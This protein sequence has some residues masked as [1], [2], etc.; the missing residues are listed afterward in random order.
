MELFSAVLKAR[1]FLA[2]ECFAGLLKKLSKIL[3]YSA[4]AI[5]FTAWPALSKGQGINLSQEEIDYIRRAGVIKAV[6]IAGV[7][8]LQY[9]NSK[10][11]VQGISWRIL[12]EISGMTGLVFEYKLYNTV[13]EGLRSDGDI[14]FTATRNYAPP[15]MALSKPFFKTE[16]IIFMNSRLEAKN[17]DEEIYAG[18]K[19]GSLPK[20]VREEKR[21][22]YDNREDCLNAV[23]AGEAGYGYGNAYSVA[24]YTLQNN[25]KN[26]IT[27]PWGKDTREYHI[28]MMKDDETL[29]GILNKA[30]DNI[31]EQTLSNL[32][33]EVTSRIERK[34]TLGVVLETYGI[35]LVSAASLLIGALLISVII[36]I[37]AKNRLLISNQRHE[38]LSRISNEYFFEYHIDCD[39]FNLSE[40]LGQRVDVANHEK[41]IKSALKT[42]RRDEQGSCTSIIKLPFIDGGT[43]VFKSISFIIYKRGGK[44]H[45]IVGKLVD[46]SQEYMEKEMLITKSQID[47]LSGLYN[48]A[49]AKELMENRIKDKGKA[50]KDALMIIDL[51]NFKGIND[52]LGHIVGDMVLQSIASIMKD[53][54]RKTD[55]LG[56]IGGDEFCVYMKDIASLDL[57]M[58]K[59]RQLNMLTREFLADVSYTVSIGIALTD[60][61]TG[62]VRELLERADKA[63]YQ[64]KG[65][66]PGQVALAESRDS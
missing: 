9:L 44:P 22:E 26:I 32:I 39:K 52:T 27:I 37:R 2:R 28:G 19:G 64:A 13:E 43:G 35:Q 59:A 54:F 6:S 12:E 50:E 21:V 17:L 45:S 10:G 36:N 47:G 53:I 1:Q 49:T 34:I 31:D 29:L 63:L 15:N 33:L 14:Y 8:P 40:K 30:I 11:E 66:G 38:L 7:A 16:T 48:S 65:K 3:A 58:G 18:V 24:Y 51:D 20:G 41:D 55:I 5:T 23:E 61:K 57:S 62:S 4:L 60:D 42:G 56:R 46:V 25:Y